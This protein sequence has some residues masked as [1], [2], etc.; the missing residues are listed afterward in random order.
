MK[1]LFAV[2]VILV[3][4]AGCVEEQSF[5]TEADISEANRATDCPVDVTEADR[6]NF[7]ACN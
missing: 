4:L 2:S 6:A 1:N 7:P 3:A 5:T